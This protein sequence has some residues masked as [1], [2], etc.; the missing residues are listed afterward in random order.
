MR[1]RSSVALPDPL[2]VDGW[3]ASASAGRYVRSPHAVLDAAPR[4]RRDDH[5]RERQQHARA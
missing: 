5:Q 2:V 1:E 3:T 4:L